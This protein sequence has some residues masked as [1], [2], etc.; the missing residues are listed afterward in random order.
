MP[1]LRIPAANEIVFRDLAEELLADPAITQSTM[2]GYPCLR[3][4][5]AFVA[6][7]ERS[8]GHLIVKLP[9]ARVNELVASRRA[10]PFTPNGRTFREWA[11]ITVADRG[12]WQAWLTEAR[13]FVDSCRLRGKELDAR[14]APDRS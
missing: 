9:A 7:V 13:A 4:H 5:G 1:E 8:T 2:M 3:S 6:C 11:A 14:P 10:L 12:Q